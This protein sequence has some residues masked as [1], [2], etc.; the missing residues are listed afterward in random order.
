[1]NIKSIVGL[2]IAAYFNTK[3]VKRSTYRNTIPTLTLLFILY[4]SP[5]IQREVHRIGGIFGEYSIGF[6]AH[7]RKFIIEIKDIIVHFHAK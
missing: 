3:F 4:V 6:P 2:Q 5:V 7:F 1:M